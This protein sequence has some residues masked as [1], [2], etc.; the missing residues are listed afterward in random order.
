MS[1]QT[2]ILEVQSVGDTI[3]GSLNQV[4]NLIDDVV[5]VSLGERNTRLPG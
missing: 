5:D 3:P 1:A 4:R 2:I